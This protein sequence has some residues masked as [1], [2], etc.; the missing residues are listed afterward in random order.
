ME[1]LLSHAASQNN[2]PKGYGLEGGI[3]VIKFRNELFQNLNW[4]AAIS[5][6][7][8]AAIVEAEVIKRFGKPH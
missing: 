1:A 6:E 8:A 4:P 7:E 5:Y 3:Q 2:P